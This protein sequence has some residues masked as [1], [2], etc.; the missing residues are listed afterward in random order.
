MLQ[1]CFLQE[2]NESATPNLRDFR[3]FW[4]RKKNNT[5]EVTL[6][7]FENLWTET[8]S[9]W[10]NVKVDAV[11]LLGAKVLVNY[12]RVLPRNVEN[13]FLTVLKN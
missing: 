13:F 3:K 12:R 6:F 11:H 9:R 4:M 7:L 5:A 2:A 10:E 8:K 1:K